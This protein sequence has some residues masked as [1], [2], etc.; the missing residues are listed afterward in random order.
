MVSSNREQKEKE[1]GGERMGVKFQ[2]D[3][4]EGIAGGL[5]SPLVGRAVEKHTR[6]VKAGEAIKKSTTQQD[7]ISQKKERMKPTLCRHTRR[8]VHGL[9]SA[10]LNQRRRKPLLHVVRQGDCF[11]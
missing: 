6:Y 9:R 11:G 8:L 2:R 3:D 4:M 7:V 5:Q 10:I 1:G